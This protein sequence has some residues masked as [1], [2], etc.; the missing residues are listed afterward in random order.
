MSPL[1]SPSGVLLVSS[2]HNLS[3]YVS[4]GAQRPHRHQP[5]LLILSVSP[6]I[7][8]ETSSDNDPSSKMFFVA[9]GRMVSTTHYQDCCHC[10]SFMNCLKYQAVRHYGFFLPFI[11][12]KILK[13]ND[14]ELYFHNINSPLFTLI[15]HIF[16]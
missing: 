7:L 6:S 5:V 10:Q 8:V 9:L 15:L 11:K 4:I 2:Q 12:F 14:L 3:A 13:W 16:Q 1:K